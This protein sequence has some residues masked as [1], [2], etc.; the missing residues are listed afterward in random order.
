M[1][2]AGPW[3]A[4]EILLVEPDLVQ[5]WSYNGIW[6]GGTNTDYAMRQADEEGWWYV[7][8][9]GANGEDIGDYT[10]SVFRAET[11]EPGTMALMGIGLAAF[12]GW[13][14]RRRKA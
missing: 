7:G 13:R 9:R 6:T 3:E 14:R 11:P 2:A 5:G 12:G 1:L 4:D 10:L 8:V